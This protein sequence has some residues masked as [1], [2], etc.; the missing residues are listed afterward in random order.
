LSTTAL[1]NGSASLVLACLKNALKEGLTKGNP[2]GIITFGSGLQ[3]WDFS[4]PFGTHKMARMLQIA[5]TSCVCAPFTP[6]CFTRYEDHPDVFDSLLDHVLEAV[7]PSRG[8]E[9][10]SPLGAALQLAALMFRQQ[11]VSGKVV[12]IY[13]GGPTRAP[14]VL[15]PRESPVAGSSGSGAAKSKEIDQPDQAALPKSDFYTKLAGHY[16][17]SCVGCDLYLLHSLPTDV[18]TMGEL[19]ILTGGSISDFAGFDVTRDGWRFEA[20][21][22][23]NIS[24]N[25]GCGGALRVRTSPGISVKTYLGPKSPLSTEID[26][27]IPLISTETTFSVEVEHD[28]RLKEGTAAFFQVAL[29]YT[30]RDGSRRVRVHNLAVPVAAQTSTV[31]K[32]LDCDAILATLVRQAVLYLRKKHTTSATAAALSDMMISAFA[33]YR[34]TCCVSPSPQQLIL[35]ES[36]RMLPILILSLNK[37]PLFSSNTI[38]DRRTVYMHQLNT[39]PV[40]KTLVHLYPKLYRLDALLDPETSEKPPQ[41]SRLGREH[42]VD[43]S[44]YLADNGTQL[45]LWFRGTP[46]SEVLAAVFGPEVDLTQTA[47]SQLAQLFVSRLSDP[48]APVS[49]LVAALSAARLHN[50]FAVSV[51]SP[52][53]DAGAYFTWNVEDQESGLVSYMAYLAHVHKCVIDKIDNHE[54]TMNAL[55]M[56][57]RH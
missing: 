1:S 28:E 51:I 10:G 7:R 41:A 12:C 5:D 36:L 31:Y 32:G 38:P 29:L 48:Q 37:S 4:K 8:K 11:R 47:A 53:E 22:R 26:V 49:K 57:H 23:H 20:D 55:A 42:I 24:Q 18:T 17:N 6:G 56:A 46:S 3:C 30:A 27:D 35:P 25:W 2:V 16:S 45:F 39:E 54:A 50:N 21:L 9:E 44:L 14:G 43:N 52:R 40:W 33:N 34:T 19:A 15:V 13:S